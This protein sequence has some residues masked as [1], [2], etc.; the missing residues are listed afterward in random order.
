[1]YI[2]CDIKYLEILIYI[3]K[4]HLCR[5]YFVH[6]ATMA[7]NGVFNGL[8]YILLLNMSAH[9]TRELGMAPGGEFRRAMAEVFIN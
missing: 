9:I 6:R 2:V 5:F 8:M 7:Q 1:M 3:F 4:V